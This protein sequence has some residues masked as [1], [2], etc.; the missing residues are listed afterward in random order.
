M[1]APLRLAV[2][3]LGRWGVHLLRNFLALP[4]AE[5]IA[6]ADSHPETLARVQAH[7]SLDQNV[8]CLLDGEQALAL[9]GLQGVAIATPA[10]T[11]YSLIK[12]ALE[13]RLHVL[14]EKPMTLDAGEGQ[15]L[16]D[17]A[18]RNGCQ[19]IVDQTYLFH[20]AI[21]AG[22]RIV[23]TQR[24]GALRYGYA[25]RTNLGPVRHDVDALWDL[26]IHDISIFNFW[27]AENPIQVAA[28][29]I[30]WL[31]PN[32]HPHFPQGLADMAWV[33]L[34]YPSRFEAVIQ[35]SWL[36]PDKQRRLGVV[37]EQG[38]LVFDELA[39]DALTLYQG[40]ISSKSPPFQPTTL[41]AVAILVETVEPLAQV[42]RHFLDCAQ[43]GVPSP[44]VSGA[45][46]TS[47]VKI[48]AALSQSL[49]RGGV[50]VSL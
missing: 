49:Q 28:W 17:L 42:C 4:G 12:A 1:T 16:C 40:A 19:L 23:Q 8:Q 20:P 9:P 6:V 2:L 24:L 31:Q 10:A 7:F 22:K 25:A 37:G 26:A 36:N 18:T 5:V 29:G 33:R 13:K 43:G 32:P 35:V 15:E 34:T 38:T 21:E 44:V 41:N 50:P 39:A 3:G 11:H 14:V 48:L 45:I 30:P 47:L 46:A 27:L